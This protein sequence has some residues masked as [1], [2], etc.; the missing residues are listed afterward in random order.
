[1]PYIHKFI[2]MKHGRQVAEFT[3][4][5]DLK[6][7]V[8]GRVSAQDGRANQEGTFILFEKGFTSRQVDRAWVFIERELEKV[9]VTTYGPHLKGLRH[10]NTEFYTTSGFFDACALVEKI[11]SELLANPKQARIAHS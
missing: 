9:S 2:G 7:S 1:M 4:R 5:D 6:Q 10:E 3:L 11:L 8:L